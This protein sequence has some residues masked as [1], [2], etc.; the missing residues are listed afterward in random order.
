[1]A[2][3]LDVTS[4]QILLEQDL[5]PNLERYVVEPGTSFIESFVTNSICCPSR[6]T[7]LTGQ[8]SHNHR[9]F[10]NT[11]TNG[12]V[13]AFDDD[14]TLATWLQ[15]AGY[16]TAHVGKYLNGYG[17]LSSIQNPYFRGLA[18]RRIAA[19]YPEAVERVEPGY[20][21]PGWN[22]WYGLV[23]LSTYCVFDYS[24]NENGRVRTYY[25]DG[26][27]LEDGRVVQ[28]ANGGTTEHYQTDVL[29]DKALEF[30]EDHWSQGDPAPFFLSVM[31]LA[32]HVENCQGAD[33]EIPPHD[34]LVYKNQFKLIIR[35]APRHRPWIDLLSATARS[36][37]PGRP[38]YNEAALE[39]KPWVLSSSLALLIPDDEDA[40]FAQF[41]HRL[42][43]MM[44]VDDLLGRIV[45]ALEDRGELDRTLIVFTS[46]NGW[47]NGEH[48]LSSKGLAYEEAVRVP[49]FVRTPGRLVPTVESRASLN[50]DLAPTFLDL[51]GG[52]ATLP[53]DGRSLLPLLDGNS[54]PVWRERFVVEHFSGFPLG[55]SRRPVDPVNVFGIRTVATS[56]LPNRTYVEYFPGVQ[57]RDGYRR[58]FGGIRDGFLWQSA[59]TSRE[60]YSLDADPYQLEN[61]WP[62]RLSM[63]E[64]R[65]IREEAETLRG[66]MLELLSCSG[67]DCQTLENP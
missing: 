13:L 20:V 29:A 4:M 25:R 17:F 44:A 23:D 63:T 56:T 16:R 40:L 53:L 33:P 5:M 65:E 15:A 27:I 41:G 19:N 8:Y 2:D 60:L 14:D 49:L 7:Y 48:R 26:R 9:T 3:D 61:R 57:Y 21:P 55:A 36:V 32:P 50:N 45:R 34:P 10:S 24:V 43:S 12:G 66:W 54:P 1:M 59:P 28:E 39:D 18:R 51:A 52:T 30:L 47:F 11:L 37:L 67:A 31:P 64:G 38:S 42:A 46:D 6:A 35:P 58:G 22:G 62:Q